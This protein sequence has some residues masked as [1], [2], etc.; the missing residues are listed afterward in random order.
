MRARTP[1]ILL[2]AALASPAMAEPVTAERLAFFLENSRAQLAQPRGPVGN[3]EAALFFAAYTGGAPGPALDAFAQATAA[4]RPQAEAY[5]ELIID[6]MERGIVCDGPGPECPPLDAPETLQRLRGLVLAEPTGGLLAG[7]VSSMRRPADTATLVDLTASHPALEDLAPLVYAATLDFDL[8]GRAAEQ[9]RASLQLLTA[10]IALPPRIPAA[11]QVAAYR[12][13][14]DRPPAG[15]D[16]EHRASAAYLLARGLLQ[17]DRP[18]EALAAIGAL[19]A[20]LRA[21]FW[22]VATTPPAAPFGMVEIGRIE[23]LFE[24]G[25]AYIASGRP[26]EAEDTAARLAALMPADAPFFPAAPDAPAP[27]PPPEML[28]Q[29]S[30][31]AAT[32]R[33]YAA[34][35]AALVREILR[36]AWT[37]DDIF[38]RMVPGAPDDVR[39]Q[40]GSGPAGWLFLMAYP[41]PHMTG[42]YP[43]Y[44]RGV[45][46][47]YLREASHP[48]LADYLEGARTAPPFPQAGSETRPD[49]V[50]EREFPAGLTP[51]PPILPGPPPV[52]GSASAAG[53]NP[54]VQVVAHLDEDGDSVTAI[55]Q[56]P[57]V[58]AAGGRNIGG[59]WLTRSPDGGGT[60]SDPVY[61]A[62][63]DAYPYRLIRNSAVPLWDGDTLR[64]EADAADFAY[65]PD[66]GGV[67]PA[68]QPYRRVLIELD[69]G[70]VTADGDGDGLADLVERR[71]GLDPA[72][73]DSDGDGMDDRAD[74]L[75]LGPAAGTP[76][77]PHAELMQAVMREIIQ[78]STPPPPGVPPPPIPG[79]T[80]AQQAARL[81]AERER[82][83]A[84]LA[85]AARAWSPLLVY[86]PPELFAGVDLDRRVLVYD[87]ETLAAIDPAY[88]E[89]SPAQLTVLPNRDGTAA[90]VRWSER[91]GGRIFMIRRTPDGWDVESLGSY[92]I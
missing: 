45:L 17:A 21:A 16:V 46:A 6:M 60:W 77:H 73:P 56:A 12:T 34:R 24:L 4:S 66:V 92:M 59:Y 49:H 89:F 8:V 78:P 44:V 83:D 65:P 5:A 63:Q 61:L 62:F 13:L 43:D 18:E 90:Y 53:P 85:F 1:A 27:P 58:D 25:M 52:P 67:I 81:A 20:D 88:G 80:A 64:L 47:S 69:W 15:A 75:P 32:Q 41:G 28:A 3:F 26:R 39:P 11:D 10:V 33:H 91:W 84:I 48:A 38:T 79:E 55:Y 54:P 30:T 68:D 35:R 19:P 76:P 40:A 42:G 70:A 31:L 51:A 72:S 2:T 9:G 37:D 36:P 86:A 57:Y 87:E 22:R 82:R 74:M 7:L 23:F 29:F 50:V 14:S 71:L